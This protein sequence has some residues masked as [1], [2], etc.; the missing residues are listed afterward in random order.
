MKAYTLVPPPLFVLVRL[1]AGLTA[2][3]LLF[4][5]TY[6]GDV[7]EITQIVYRDAEEESDD[8][9]S[10]SLPYFQ[11]SEIPSAAFHARF[12][13][14]DRFV[15][16]VPVRYYLENYSAFAI[17]STSYSDGKY[18][19]LNRYGGKD[20]PLIVDVRNDTIY[21]PEWAGY[22]IRTNKELLEADSIYDKMLK[23]LKFFKGQKAQ[24]F[25]LAKYGMKI[26]GGTD[27]A[28]IP[29]CVMNQLFSCPFNIRFV[30]NGN[31][32]YY[33]NPYADRFYG[34]F[35]ESSWYKND[36]GSVAERPA[37]L[38]ELSYNMLRFTHDY[39]YGQPGYYGF[40]DDG[41]GYADQTIVLAAD[42]LDFDT[43]LKNYDPQTRDLL[44]SSSYLDY[45]KGLERLAG[46]TYG[47]LHTGVDW[48]CIP[49]V[50]L[51]EQWDELVAF[52]EA[53]YSGKTKAIFA[54][55]DVLPPK[56]IASGKATA[57]EDVKN[58]IPVALE[59]L[60]GGKTAVI[61]FDEFTWKEWEWLSYYGKNI[62]SNPDPETVDIPDDTMSFFYRTFYTI[63]NDSDY[64]DV[65]NVII[66]LSCN[67]G[68][69]TQSCRNALGYLIGGG[70]YRFYDAHTD[71]M[72]VEYTTCD[73]NLDGNCDDADLAYHARLVTPKGEAYTDENGDE[74]TDGRGLHFAVL[75]SR[76]S[77]SCANMFPTICADAG[78]PI[79]GEPSGG[80]TCFVAWAITVDGFPYQYS[81]N[82][83]LAREDGSTVENGVP[84]TKPLTYDQFYDD[85]ALQAVMDELISEGYYDK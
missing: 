81:G 82:T 34:S 6:E 54:L 18:K 55:D 7:T 73:L 64:A 80:G 10:A 14:G 46:Y 4:S 32:V 30:Y 5:C 59:V 60:S 63:L 24:T 33:I 15:P 41:S 58:G 44:T 3:L 75:T 1:I 28:Y 52:S 78:I 48:N 43:L 79:I 31:G 49:K 50:Y 40:A 8:F 22:C 17:E 37:E 62:P 13:G 71:T 36:D 35:S 53:T 83:R 42:K 51:P 76:S 16:Y 47:D 2:A 20:F 25:E 70:A 69:A 57:S 26:Y 66:D 11:E 29:L 74:H 68:G 85:A 77:F 65:E 72:Y 61:R 84:V 67:V 27:D 38:A 12:Y 56:R 21:C 23:I 45:M 19:Y 9:V 39:L